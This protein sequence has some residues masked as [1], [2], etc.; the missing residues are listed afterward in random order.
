MECGNL[1]EFGE[2]FEA[3]LYSAVTEG[4]E[5]KEIVPERYEVL[6][7]VFTEVSSLIGTLPELKLF[8]NFTSGSVT[9]EVPAIHLDKDGALRLKEVLSRCNT[10]EILPLNDGTVRASVTVKGVFKTTE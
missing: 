7:Q 6:S 8:P 3:L 4:N 2:V 10:F 9:V 1:Y 5:N